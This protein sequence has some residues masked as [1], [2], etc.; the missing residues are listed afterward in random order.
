MVDNSLAVEIRK[1]LPAFYER[2]RQIA[3]EADDQ[4]AINALKYLVDRV[5]GAPHAAH[6]PSNGSL[7][8]PAVQ[9]NIAFVESLRDH[10]RS[11]LLTVPQEARPIGA[12]HP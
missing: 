11:Q 2:F 12:D 1:D 8:A 5:A 9:V 10:V 6:D 3:L 7:Q 4:H